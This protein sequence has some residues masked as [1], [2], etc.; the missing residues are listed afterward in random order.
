M[1][2]SRFTESLIVYAIKQSETGTPVSEVCLKMGVSSANFYICK[3][4]SGSLG[5]SEL[6]RF[7][8]LEE[9]NS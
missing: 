5:V 6:R 3:K 7:K 8:S 1:K 2:K 4:K 9:E